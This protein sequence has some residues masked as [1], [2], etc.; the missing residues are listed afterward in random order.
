MGWEIDTAD[1]DSLDNAVIGIEAMAD[2]WRQV[3]ET[4]GV[5]DQS[6]EHRVAMHRTVGVALQRLHDAEYRL[7]CAAYDA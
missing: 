2:R 5:T 4:L 1:M 7:F 3:I 6:K